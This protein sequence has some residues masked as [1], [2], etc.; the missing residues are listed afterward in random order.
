MKTPILIAAILRL[1][2]PGL[3]DSVTHPHPLPTQPHRVNLNSKFSKPSPEARSPRYRPGLVQT[4]CELPRH[5]TLLWGTQ[6]NAG[7]ITQEIAILLEERHYK[8]FNAFRKAFWTAVSRS[9]HAEEFS[10]ENQRRLEKG[11]A[12]IAPLSQQNHAQSLYELHHIQPIRHN[13]AVYDL[14]NLMIVTPRYH[15]EVLLKEYHYETRKLNQPAAD[16]QTI[17]RLK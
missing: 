15:E 12:P 10:L 14:C 5:R 1:V 9:S 3:P 13:G 8:S 16:H 17:E 2:H 4:S 6:Q 7:F 11:C